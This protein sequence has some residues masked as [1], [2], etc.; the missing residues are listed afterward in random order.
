MVKMAVSS[1]MDIGVRHAM[2]VSKI[3]RAQIF[4]L[5]KQYHLVGEFSPL[6]KIWHKTY[7]IRDRA[8]T[9]CGTM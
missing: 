2:Q 6:P 8:I 5:W 7:E 3:D 4:I 9:I 1:C